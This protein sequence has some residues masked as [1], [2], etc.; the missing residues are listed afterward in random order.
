MPAFSRTLASAIVGVAVLALVYAFLE[1]LAAPDLVGIF[2]GLLAGILVGVA[3]DD[4]LK[5]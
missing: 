1:R 2:C 5:R 3:F 4:W